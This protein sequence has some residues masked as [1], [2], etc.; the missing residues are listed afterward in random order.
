MAKKILIY[1]VGPFGS[2]FAERL[3][4]AGHDIAVLDHGERQ[5][6]LKRFGVVIENTATGKITVTKVPVVDNFD[7]EAYYDLVI[8]PMR[9]NKVIE[10]LPTLGANKKVPTFLFMMNNAE[11]QE[12]LVNALGQERVVSGFPFPGGYRQGNVIRMLPVDESHKWTLPIGEVDGRTLPRTLEVKAVLESMRG[13]KVEIRDDIDDWLKTHVA[14]LVPTLAQA[15]YAC[16]TDLERFAATRDARVLCIRALREAFK[17]LRKAGVE[18]TPPGLRVLETIPEPLLVLMLAKLARSETF[19]NSLG[20]LK[21]V[22][23]EVKQLTDEFYELI[24]P[25]GME[26]PALDILSRYS[27]TD[28]APLPYGLTAYPLDWKAVYAIAGAAVAAIGLYKWMKKRA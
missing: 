15:V 3:M 20:H 2:L 12:R 10:I 1:G 5:A 4:E 14:L 25:A 11:G 8:V 17:A 21:S 27:Y 7:P 26:T 13:F 28:K 16:G 18:I 9:K 19:E 22:P 24:E 23:D 6:D